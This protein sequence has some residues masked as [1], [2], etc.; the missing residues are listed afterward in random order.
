MLVEESINDSVF[1]DQP[2]IDLTKLRIL[3]VDDMELSRQAIGEA[4]LRLGISADM[5]VDGNDALAKVRNALMGQQAYDVILLDWKM[6]DIDGIELASIVNQELDK[7]SPE[8]VLLSAY[9]MASLQELGN[10]LGIRYF[11]QK[12]LN[13]SSL[14]DCLIEVASGHSPDHNVKTN[15]NTNTVPDLTGV[16]ILLVE[17]NALNRKVATYFLEETKATITPAQNGKIALEMLTS[18]PNYNLV[19]MDIQMP[20][21]DG[22]TAT[23]IIRNDLQLDVP[24]IAMTAHAMTGDVEKSLAAGMNAHVTKPIDPEYLYRVI[25]QTLDCSVAETNE[26]NE[27]KLTYVVNESSTS[28]N[29]RL[30][31]LDTNTALQKLG[32]DK[33]LYQSLISDFLSLSPELDAL[34]QAR[35]NSNYEEVSRITHIYCSALKYIGAYNLAELADT[36]QES[37]YRKEHNSREF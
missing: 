21:M 37:L 31:I 10:P 13:S 7:N 1:H 15:V 11:L 8:I 36:L 12:P 19:F 29:D 27:A 30:L 9:D 24:I 16:E 14:Y 33:S 35:E 23:R 25:N 18:R 3:V 4:L 6:D 2:N 17:D 22:L 34:Q 28:L 20:E 32:E 5:S 26:V